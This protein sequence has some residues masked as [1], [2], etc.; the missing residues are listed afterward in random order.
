MLEDKIQFREFGEFCR[1]ENC[2][3]NI[4]KLTISNY[5]YIIKF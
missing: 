1:K 3:E 2:V 5:I 4:V